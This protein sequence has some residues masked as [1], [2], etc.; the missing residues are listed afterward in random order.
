MHGN[1]ELQNFSRLCGA[2]ARAYRRNIAPPPPKPRGGPSALA[3]ARGA[4]RSGYLCVITTHALFARKVQR[5]V[6]NGVAVLAAVG[7]S[8]DRG[9]SAQL[10]PSRTPLESLPLRI[11]DVVAQTR[12]VSAGEFWRSRRELSRH[13]KYIDRTCLAHAFPSSNP[14][15]PAS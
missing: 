14:L 13:L 6:S 2:I 10:A 8:L 7:S 11:S 3:G 1:D 5:K 4:S 9:K 15:S 12:I